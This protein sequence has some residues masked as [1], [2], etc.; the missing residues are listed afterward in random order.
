MKTFD[1]THQPEFYQ[2]S[3]HLENL[4]NYWHPMNTNRMA[5]DQFYSFDV[6]DILEALVPSIVYYSR[7]MF[8]LHFR[9]QQI[10]HYYGHDTVANYVKFVYDKVG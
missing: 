10:L 9:A 6:K 1:L 8:P 2:L 7:E 4:S 5:Q 3:I